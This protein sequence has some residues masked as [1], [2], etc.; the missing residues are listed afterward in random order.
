MHVHYQRD[1]ISNC[2]PYWTGQ[3]DSMYIVEASSF[4]L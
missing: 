2:G 3:A 4:E 1:I